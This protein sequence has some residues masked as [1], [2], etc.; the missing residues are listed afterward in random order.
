MVPD[1]PYFVPSPAGG[2]V[3]T[4]AW[5]GPI[6]LDLIMGIGL[7]I[8]WQFLL[9]VPLADM[10]P[11]W[12]RLRLPVPRA[13]DPERCVAAGVSVVIGATTHVLWDTFTHPDRW[14]R[15]ICRA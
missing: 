11:A 15:P 9:R 7:W 2:T 8:A 13:L 6:T 10:S 14:V 3:T 4:H 1:L 5:Y 12:L